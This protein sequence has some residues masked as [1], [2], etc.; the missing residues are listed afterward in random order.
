M[1]SQKKI[2]LPE[3]LINLAKKIPFVPVGIVCAHHQ[4]S[5]LTS[6]QAYEL[7]LINPTF[8]GE[9]NL[10]QKEAEKLKWNIKDFIIID[11]KLDQDA[12]TAGALLASEKKI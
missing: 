6:K 7:G 1:L 5:M 9:I 11:K 3:N 12:A 10:I 2:V 4:S 8:I